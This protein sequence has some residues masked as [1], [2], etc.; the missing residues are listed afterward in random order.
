M[1]TRVSKKDTEPEDVKTTIADELT[2]VLFI[3]VCLANK[4]GIPKKMHRKNIQN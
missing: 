1:G 3:I 4:I 2:D